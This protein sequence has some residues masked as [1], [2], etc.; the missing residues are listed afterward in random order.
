MK[1]D[2][3]LNILYFV[4]YETGQYGDRYE[5]FDNITDAYNF[6]AEMGY[7]TIYKAELVADINQRNVMY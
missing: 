3:I 4:F 6:A 2:K 7:A 5:T 1:S